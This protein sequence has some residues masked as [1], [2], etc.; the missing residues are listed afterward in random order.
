MPPA[1]RRALRLAT[2]LF[3]AAALLGGPLATRSALAQTP[4][5]DLD[6]IAPGQEADRAAEIA[7][8]QARE[9]A[10]QEAQQAAEEGPAAERQSE[11]DQAKSRAMGNALG[12]SLIGVASLVGG[13]LFLVES[14]DSRNLADI[15]RLD[16][17][18]RRQAN[19]EDRADRQRILGITLTSL[20]V[21]LVGVATW[22]WIDY[23]QTRNAPAP[24][25]TLLPSVDPS[26]GAGL[27]FGG[28]F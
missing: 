5:G 3:L 17:D 20:G 25:L 12:V 11:A 28:R 8:E 2:T 7:E 14:G 26:G 1:P 22:L 15:A 27:V 9:Q 4:P 23:A 24:R 6:V 13:I 21:A 16:G 18:E 10:E 19:L